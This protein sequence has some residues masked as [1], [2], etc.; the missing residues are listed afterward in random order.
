VALSL[1]LLAV[2]VIGFVDLS[3]AHVSG[4]VYLAVPLLVI[5]TAL[6]IGARYERA[7][8]LIIPGVVLTAAL[9]IATAA[10]RATVD[11]RS[12]TWRPTT[13]DQ[14]QST[15]SSG[16]GDAVLDL[17]RLNFTGLTQSVSVESDV[18]NVTVIVPPTVDVRADVRVDVGNADVFGTQWAGIGQPTHTV[19]DD[20]V[21]GK[22]GGTL[23][24]HAATDVGNV[25]V[26]R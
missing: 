22:G 17:S 23:V 1:S 18:G 21:D 7:R 19:A 10:E 8:W 12:S 15:Y 20:G 16:V 6:V 24:I 26:R 11:N 9:D 2:G 4:G 25:E 5:G 14:L 3:G 13:V